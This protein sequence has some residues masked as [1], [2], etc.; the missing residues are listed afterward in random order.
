MTEDIG[1]IFASA[2]GAA[3]AAIGTG[4]GRVN[5]IG[6]HTDYNDGFVMPCI[7]S[8]ATHVALALRD[9]DAVHGHSTGFGAASAARSSSGPSPP[10]YQPPASTSDACRRAVRAMA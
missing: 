10:A 2:F 5:L 7:L 6:E 8:H 4:H 1:A 9:D 3:P